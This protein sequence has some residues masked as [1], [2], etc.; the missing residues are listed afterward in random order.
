VVGQ[1]IRNIEWLLALL[2]TAGDQRLP[3]LAAEHGPDNQRDT[4]EVYL[5]G[6]LVIGDPKTSLAVPPLCSPSFRLLDSAFPLAMRPPLPSAGLSNAK[7]HRPRT[8][9][10]MIV[11]TP[12]GSN[13][14]L[15]YE[16]KPSAFTVV[17]SPGTKGED[18]IQLT[19]WR[20][21]TET[22]YTGV[23]LPCRPLGVV[24]L[25]RRALRGR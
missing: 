24:D 25:A 6:L 3:V 22:T 10:R 20:F 12:R 21:M 8:L 5:L 18:G 17:S 23:I 13:I 19:H 1:G 11:E 2:E 15:E 14:K 7:L 4:L 16:S 9:R